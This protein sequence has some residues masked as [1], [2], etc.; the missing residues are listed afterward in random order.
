M[1]YD[2]EYLEKNDVDG[3]LSSAVITLI[4]FLPKLRVAASA[5]L[6]RA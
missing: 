3:Y 5:L 4:P 6:T 2:E 1:K